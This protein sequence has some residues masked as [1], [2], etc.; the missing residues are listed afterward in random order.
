[1]EKIGTMK[2]E[3][4]CKAC[5]PTTQSTKLMWKHGTISMNRRNSLPCLSNTSRTKNCLIPIFMEEGPLGPAT[6][7]LFPFLQMVTLTTPK[8]LKSSFNMGNCIHIHVNLILL[9][10]NESNLA[11]YI[12]LFDIMGNNIASFCPILC[13]QR[14]CYKC[15]FMS[16]NNIYTTFNF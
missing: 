6:Q 16:N 7:P 15:C 2:W 11:T 4:S 14:Q 12:L 8:S 9:L 13:K 3:R 1:M 10:T 5:M